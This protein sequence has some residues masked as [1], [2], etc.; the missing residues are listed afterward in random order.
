[1]QIQT[2]KNGFTLI[3]IILY[4]TIISIIITIIT[5]FGLDTLKERGEQEIKQSVEQD[6]NFVINKITS[7]I[8]N[9][10]KINR[11]ES[12][13]GTSLPNGKI[14]LNKKNNTVVTI[15]LSGSSV[16]YQEGINSP[17]R[18][19]SPDINITKLNFLTNTTGAN[20]P[21]EIQVKLELQTN[22]IGVD[23]PYIKEFQTSIVPKATDTDEDECLDI[24]DQFPL[25]P[26]CCQDTDGDSF[27]DKEDNCPLIHNTDQRDDDNDNIGF[28]CDDS[29][30]T[31]VGGEEEEGIIGG[32]WAGTGTIDT[33]IYSC[34]YTHPLW[35]NICQ[36]FECFYTG[37]KNRFETD[38]DNDEYA[39]VGQTFSTE[40]EN[41]YWKKTFSITDI[42]D[43]ALPKIDR[44]KFSLNYCHG[45][46]RIRAWWRKARCSGEGYNIN[47]Y[48]VGDQTLELFNRQ[49]GTW[50]QIGIL[51]SHLTNNDEIYADFEYSNNIQEYINTDKEVTLRIKFKSDGAGWGDPQRWNFLAPT[52]YLFLD[53]ILMEAHV[54]DTATC[55]DAL[56][57]MDEQ[58]DDGSHC[59]DGTDCT[60][61][62]ATIC[63]G[64]GD[65]LCKPRDL[66]G[67]DCNN[68]CLNENA[69]CGNTLIE[70][71]EECDDGNTIDNDGCS[72]SC[73]VEKCGNGLLDAPEECDSGT[74]CDQNNLFCALD[75]ECAGIGDE[76]CKMRNGD[77]DQC[78]AI[79]QSEICSNGRIDA[80][81]ECDDSNTNDGD[82]CNSICKLETCTNGIIDTGEACDDGNNDDN[83]DC[84]NSCQIQFCGDGVK[85]RIIEECDD[86]RQCTDNTPCLID[87][88]CSGIG[89]SL[90]KVRN[91][92]GCDETCMIEFSVCGNAIIEA[93]EE[94]DDSNINDGDGCSHTCMTEYTSMY[95][96]TDNSKNG[97]GKA[98]TAWVVVSSTN[99]PSGGPD[100]ST[101]DVF[102]GS[103]PYQVE[104]NQ[105]DQLTPKTLGESYYQTKFSDDERFRLE[106]NEND[107]VLHKFDFTLEESEFRGDETNPK[108][109]EFMDITW[110]GYPAWDWPN[111]RDINLYIW[112]SNDNN[113]EEIVSDSWSKWS[114][115]ET[116]LNHKIT[117]KIEDYVDSNRKIYL[118]VGASRK[119]ENMLNTDHL[120]INIKAYGYRFG[121]E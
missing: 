21:K 118:L 121:Y 75:L 95:D 115:S 13:F 17:E 63:I 40:A 47:G 101:E 24:I 111:A 78:S 20:T 37:N 89:D 61:S 77:D 86:G 55:G 57:E 68:V 85:N 107:Y 92:D 28:A 6:A 52:R 99:L 62:G 116:K 79:C 35:Q 26:A 109:I 48:F 45:G 119:E 11:F 41:M 4:V 117:D 120:Q 50:D 91:L 67:N 82:G 27:C 90:C 39:G 84:N 31:G 110:E 2:N 36:K 102:G 106:I 112:N 105:I 108:R 65:E 88:T 46:S 30:D 100:F 3:E 93:G 60:A 104:F 25:D 98:R 81:E 83:D 44:L 54:Q 12:V 59:S 66:I 10:K 38:E 33:C 76:L 16:Y 5:N 72:S 64:V 19:S 73:K 8:E 56:I 58:C 74:R 87:A 97:I 80:N 9:A 103:K 14:V 69:V 42:D 49:T 43:E 34:N 94:C 23:N 96:F 114:S 70:V 7:E 53:Y 51:E 15:S 113:W 29:V 32:T 1:M 71:G 18:I 22:Q